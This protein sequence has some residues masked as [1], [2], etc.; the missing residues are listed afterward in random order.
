MISVI[1]ALLLRPVE[2]GNAHLVVTRL[3]SSP[4]H[5]PAP[6]ASAGLMT[7]CRSV[8]IGLLDPS[9]VDEAASPPLVTTFLDA[10][11]RVRHASFR[12]AAS[13][14]NFLFGR[15]LAK[16]LVARQF[17]CA[18]SEVHIAYDRDGKPLFAEPTSARLV[19][20][21][22][23][24][25]D[26][27]VA[28]ATGGVSRLGIDVENVDR[29][30]RHLPLTRRILAEDEL[31]DV[32]ACSQAG[33]VDRFLQYWTLKEAWAKS[34]GVGLGARFSDIEFD[35]QTSAAPAPMTVERC[36][37][38]HGPTSLARVGNR[39]LLALS[40][41]GAEAVRIEWLI[42]NPHQ[43]HDNLFQAGPPKLQFLPA[44]LRAVP[45]DHGALAG[46]DD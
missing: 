13:K 21:S 32:L 34:V 23:S 17:A 20:V 39:H 7:H 31:R 1:R 18:P 2:V 24:H 4:Y 25:T 12:H 35:L 5:C 26:G 3:Q 10:M 28:V 38:L 11:E 19:S 45:G 8:S 6:R 41:G 27:L 37:G 16:S 30:A 9:Q 29:P 43:E 42:W 22:I 14:R 36:S 33:R 44:S 40:F 46:T 15:V